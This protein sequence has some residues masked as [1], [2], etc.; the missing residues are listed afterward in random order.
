MV[1]WL[2]LTPVF[3]DLDRLPPSTARWFVSNPMT[4]VVAAH[5][6][7][8]LHGELPAW[9]PLATVAIVSA[10]ILGLS[11]QSFRTREDAFIEQTW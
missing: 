3:C 2:Y 4:A 7:I 1:L 10:V 9:R 11:L 6:A 8:T 5:R